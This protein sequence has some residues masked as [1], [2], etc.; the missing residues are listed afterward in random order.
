MVCGQTSEGE[1]EIEIDSDPWFN[2]HVVIV[3]YKC[4]F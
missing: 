4:V 2:T 1:K 3:L